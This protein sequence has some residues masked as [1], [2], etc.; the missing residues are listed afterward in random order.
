MVKMHKLTKGGQTIFPATIYDAVVNPKTHKSLTTELSELESIGT[1]NEDTLNYDNGVI[2][3]LSGH[4]CYIFLRNGKMIKY[5]PESDEHYDI[6]NYGA[7]VYD[8]SDNKIKAVVY[9]EIRSSHKVL[10]FRNSK[11]P[12]FLI[13]GQWYNS[14]L[15]RIIKDKREQLENKVAEL[16]DVTFKFNKISLRCTYGQDILHRR[17]NYSR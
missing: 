14:Y 9:N 6:A 15:Q 2:T 5:E 3:L 10:L 13:G 8:L 7:L 4:P 16:Q 12:N 17:I 1:V 11:E